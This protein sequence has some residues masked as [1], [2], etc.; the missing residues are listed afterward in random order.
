MT[1]YAA[2]LLFYV[3]WKHK[4]Q[5]RYP[6]WENIVLI[7]AKS[8]Q[9][10][11]TKAEKRA[12]EDPCMDPDDSFTWEGA[13]AEWVFAGIRKL[14][15]C[16]DERRRPTDGTEVTYLELEVGSRADLDKLI[17]GEPVSVRIEDGFPEEAATEAA[18][19]SRNGR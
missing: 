19:S 15:L 16:V 9:E 17:A 18:V 3:R 10:A 14:T 1:W 11:F 12:H 5:T 2:Q 6:V 7:G 8:E 4:R 13:P